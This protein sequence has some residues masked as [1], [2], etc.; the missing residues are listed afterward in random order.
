MDII[1]ALVI[2]DDKAVRMI[3]V[4][5]L[6]GR[7][8]NVLAAADTGE[9]DAI[10]EK[11]KIDVI[12]CDVLL[13]DEDGLSYCQRLRSAGVRVPLMF[14][15]TLGDPVTVSI[16]MTSGASAYMVKPFDLQELYERICKLACGPSPSA[17]TQA[18]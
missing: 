2:D 17:D 11:E 8:V 1:N 12:V 16:G 18:A 15:S 7:G 3:A 13:E 9:A 4:C 10:L 6:S 5:G 14:L